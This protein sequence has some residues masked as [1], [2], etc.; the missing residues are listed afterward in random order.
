MKIHIDI[1]TKIVPRAVWL[2]HL[3]FYDIETILDKKRLW[4]MDINNVSGYHSFHNRRCVIHLGHK[5][6]KVG[7]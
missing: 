5:G 1:S 4:A 3:S 6:L 7:R 2:L